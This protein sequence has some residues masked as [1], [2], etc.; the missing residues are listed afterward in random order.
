VI[1][2]AAA[3]IVL[4]GLDTVYDGGPK[5][6]SA[7]TTPSGL[8]VAFTYDGNPA[9]PTAAGSYAV[10][11]TIDDPNHQGSASG[12]LVISKAA[13]EIVLGN[14]EFAEDGT[15]KEVT[16]TTVPGGLDLEILYNGSE[17]APSSEGT[18]LVEVIVN[19]ANYF[20]E[21]SAQM[22]ILPGA[23][24]DAYDEWA[25][26]NFSSEE[27]DAGLALPDADAD[28]DGTPNLA[29]FYL[30]LDPRDPTSRL[31]MTLDPSVPQLLINRVVT[32]GEFVIEASENPAG[33]WQDLQTLAIE[34]EGN[35]HP[36]E[37][38]IPSGKRFFRLRYTPPSHGGDS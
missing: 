22:I 31:T 12:T 29:E 21:A 38:A 32:E 30:G 4:G 13:A 26:L 28:G 34:A 20:G 10:V 1:S 8:E 16:V 23:A 5:A 19:D 27:V 7:T 9:E 2:K 14:L 24:E 15:T 25:T 35:D 3:E 17:A 6:A 18:Y 11:A 33:P 37:L 36:V